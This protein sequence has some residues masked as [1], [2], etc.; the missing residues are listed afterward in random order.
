MRTE[1]RTLAIILA[2][3]ACVGGGA[4][5]TSARAQQPPTEP[6]VG[7]PLAL[8][9]R[10]AL[11]SAP[12]PRP[13]VSSGLTSPQDRRQA[14][15]EYWGEGLPTADKLDLFDKFWQYADAKFAA[16]Q[17]IVVD[18]AALRVR[19]RSEV[20]AG[21]SRGRFAAIMNQ[22]SLALRDSH[23]EAFDLPVNIFSVPQRGVPLLA[24]SAWT[25]DSSG[26][27]KPRRM[28]G[29]PLCT[30]LSPDTLLDS[31]PVTGSSGTTERRGEN[32][33][34]RCCERNC[35]CGQS[36]GVHHRVPSTTHSSWRPA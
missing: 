24:L 10:A 9:A 29:P 22:L 2:A 35:R 21:V 33:I 17:G 32:C 18:W 28:T 14:I 11:A 7:H 36:G 34:S 13:P 26:I 30:R 16:F 6:E 4:F 19:Y 1:V 5:G 23:T 3:A 25:Y 15:D 27:A 20:A 8:A 31:S 12:V